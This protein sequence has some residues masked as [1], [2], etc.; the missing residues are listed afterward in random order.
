MQLLFDVGYTFSIYLIIAL[1][2]HIIYVTT[3]EFNL[4]HAVTIVSGPY[5]H[6]FLS[7]HLGFSIYI[8]IPLALFCAVIIGVIPELTIY[9]PIRKRSNIPYA[10]LIS[11]LGFYTIAINVI[12]LIFGDDIKI[13][14][15]GEVLSGNFIGGAYVASIQIL[16]IL[17]S[18]I[19]FFSFTWFMKNS[20]LGIRLRSVSSNPNL[21]EILGIS[22]KKIYLWS[23][24]IGSFFAAIVGLLIAYDTGMY[25]TMGFSLLFYG[26]VAMIIGG[27]GSNKGIIIGSLFLSAI[28]HLVSYTWGAQWMD[29]ITYFILIIFLIFKPKGFGGAQLKKTEL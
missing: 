14:K 5:I 22:T 6:Y 25:T 15:T 12:S 23:Y 28:Q 20:I 24:L 26:I 11:S 1:S 10:V 7:I 4:S 27:I 8:A 19:L 9:Q 13:L 18:I 21:A 17:I 2:Y 3:R 29:A 16:S